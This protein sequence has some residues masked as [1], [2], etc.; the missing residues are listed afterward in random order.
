MR[1]V[2]LAYARSANS[3]FMV[4]PPKEDQRGRHS[5]APPAQS[6]QCKNGHHAQCIRK[7]CTCSCGHRFY[8]L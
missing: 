1:F 4:S 8:N 2:S 6:W 3:R 7:N 5:S